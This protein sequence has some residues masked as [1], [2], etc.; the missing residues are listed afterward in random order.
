MNLG[1]SE[2][3]LVDYLIG[4]AKS[5]ERFLA[6]CNNKNSELGEKCISFSSLILIQV[7]HAC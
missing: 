2:D 7:L 6:W 3:I 5:P 1:V 4:K